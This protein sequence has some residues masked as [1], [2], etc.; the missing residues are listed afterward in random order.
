VA[1]VALLHHA[2]R[3]EHGVVHADGEADDHHELRDVGCER[4]DLADR[5]EQADRADHGGRA[6]HERESGGDER[7][8]RDQQDDQHQAVGDELRLRPI[9]GVLGGDLLG[10]RGVAELLDANAGVGLLHRGDGGERLVDEL[11]DLLVGAAH[12]EVHRDG[13]A[14]L[15]D[16]V[17]PVGRVE[18]ALDLRDA[19]DRSE[20]AHDVLHGRG[21]LRIIRA[22]ALD[23]HLL[24]RL[25]RE[26]GGRDEHVA[27]LGLA[28]ARRRLVDLVQPDPSAD[29]GGEHDEQ[30]PAEDGRLAMLRAPSTGSRGEI[31]GLIQRPVLLQ[32]AEGLGAASQCRPSRR[33]GQTGVSK[34]P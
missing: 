30:D 15:G 33:W 5:T 7:A 2:A 32:G 18:R 20:P 12:R 11:L 9:L 24:A 4:V 14:V 27:P 23:E 34:W 28:A 26:P 16:G 21:D 19:R 3:I 13:P 29:D 10:G 1:A 6:E 8:E 17:E 25:I 22:L 31:T